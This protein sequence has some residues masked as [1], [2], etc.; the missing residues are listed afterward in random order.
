MSLRLKLKPNE[1]IIIGNT[2][3]EN[4][5]KSASFLVHNKATILREKDILTELTATT[6]AKRIYFIVQL[7]YMAGSLEDSKNQHTEFFHLSR[8]FM[9][10]CPTEKAILMVSEIG[11][12]ILAEDLYGALKI[13]NKLIEYEQEVMSKLNTGIEK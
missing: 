6:P 3:I 2:V 10:A 9:T 4:G 5:P 13:C 11:D 12:K 1:K 8:D 7:M